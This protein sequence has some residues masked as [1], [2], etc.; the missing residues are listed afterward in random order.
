MLRLISGGVILVTGIA[1]SVISLEFSSSAFIQ[2]ISALVLIASGLCLAFLERVLTIE[3]NE[4]AIREEWLLAGFSLR[5]RMTDVKRADQI[6]ICS[7]QEPI[8]SDAGLVYVA[9]RTY[10]VLVC[11]G[12]K[13][14]VRITGCDS[15]SEGAKKQFWDISLPSPAFFLSFSQHA[16]AICSKALNLP[17]NDGPGNR[18]YQPGQIPQ[19]WLDPAHV[20]AVLSWRRYALPDSESGRPGKK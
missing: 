4:A 11:D 1:L 3:A 2:L 12:N 13:T 19:G 20:K 10:P 8:I 5:R 16:A 15:P 9:D 6:R 7:R 18:T 14:L 17:L